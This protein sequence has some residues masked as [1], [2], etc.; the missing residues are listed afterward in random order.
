M[1]SLL[2][3]Y[4]PASDLKKIA[5]GIKK[6]AESQGF[7]VDIKNTKEIERVISLHP[8]DLV[9]AGSKAEGIFASDIDS[10]LKDFLAE[11]KRT[12][13][14]DAFAFVKPY[15]FATNKTLKKIMAVLESEGC[16]VKNFKRLKNYHSAVEFGKNIKI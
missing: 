16:I 5:E 11:A 1:Q 3:I 14:R 15:F 8:Y 9:L 10:S 2:V 7:K 12:Q 13:G 4:T 6:G